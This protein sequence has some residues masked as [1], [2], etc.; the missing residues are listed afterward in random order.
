MSSNA[1]FDVILEDAVTSGLETQL[2][3]TAKV[4]CLYLDPRIAIRK[5][6]FYAKCLYKC[7]PVPGKI[8]ILLLA[9]SRRLYEELGIVFEERKN[10][11]LSDFSDCVLDAKKQYEAFQ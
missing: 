10:W 7:F 1:S 6:D 9:I 5:P 8:E 4:L 11:K 3:E 2:G